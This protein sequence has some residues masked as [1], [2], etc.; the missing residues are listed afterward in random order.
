VNETTPGGSDDDLLLLLVLRLL[1]F[2]SLLADFFLIASVDDALDFFIIFLVTVAFFTVPPNR[3]LLEVAVTVN[4]LPSLYTVL[5]SFFCL[6]FVS[7]AKGGARNSDGTFESWSGFRSNLIF[8]LIGDDVV[9]VGAVLGVEIL[10]S[11]VG[12]GEEKLLTKS[13]TLLDRRNRSRYAD[14]GVDVTF[15]SVASSISSSSSSSVVMVPFVEML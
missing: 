2:L 10:V 13:A 15:S 3:L 9:V 12:F 5:G 7:K 14:S 4:F 1:L 8:R 6:G 11:P